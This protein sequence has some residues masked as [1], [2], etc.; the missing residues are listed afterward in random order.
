VKEGE[1][2][3]LAKEALDRARALAGDNEEAVKEVFINMMYA[4]P[5]L[6]EALTILGVAR[7]WES[8]NLRH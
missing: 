2:K 5:Q 6:H 7:L 8:Q 4:S 1:A 3:R